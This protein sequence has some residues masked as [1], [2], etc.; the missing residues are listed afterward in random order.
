[1]IFVLK[2]GHNDTG[3]SNAMRNKNITRRRIDLGS[4]AEIFVKILLPKRDWFSI[5]IS[6]KSMVPDFNLS[7]LEKKVQPLT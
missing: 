1:M 5:K 4:H 3:Q 6:M 7:L 2:M